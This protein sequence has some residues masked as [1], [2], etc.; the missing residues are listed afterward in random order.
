M[1]KL[2]MEIGGCGEN[3][4]Q[5]GTWAVVGKLRTRYIGGCVCVWGGGGGEDCIIM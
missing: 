3:C 1:A 2:Y 4:E 5:E